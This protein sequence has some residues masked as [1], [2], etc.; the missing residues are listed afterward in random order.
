MKVFSSDLELLHSFTH[1]SYVYSVAVSPDSTMIVFGDTEGKMFAW[2]VGGGSWERT[3]TW[4]DHTSDAY[5]VVFSPNGK[6]LATGS[7]DETNNVY[8][9]TNGF[10]RIHTL[11]G[12]T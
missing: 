8:N 1:E 12:H 11:E 2:T 10:S 4:K 3:K 6:M 7:F 9:V 5:V